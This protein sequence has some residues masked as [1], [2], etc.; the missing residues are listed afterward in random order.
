[1]ARRTWQLMVGSLLVCAVA[2][3]C[4]RTATTSD[5]MF[6]SSGTSAA[7]SGR[8]SDSGVGGPDGSGG[9]TADATGAGGASGAGGPGGAGNQGVG[10]VPRVNPK[11]FAAIIGLRDIHFEFDRYTIRPDQAPILDA[12]AEWLKENPRALLLIEGHADERGTNEYNLALG[13]R[14]ARAAM[15]YLVAQGVRSNRISVISYGEDRP[16]CRESSEDCWSQNRRAHFSI[17]QR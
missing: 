12:N 3:G 7:V 14:R 15:S 6:E 11:E 17:K 16:V 5:S 10:T 13:D 2:A 8:A 1:M 4:A 9:W